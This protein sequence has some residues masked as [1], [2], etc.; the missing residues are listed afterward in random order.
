DFTATRGFL[1]RVSAGIDLYQ[2]VP[3]ATWLIQ[4]IDPL[5]GEVLQ[6]TT[7]GLLKPNDAL[8]SGAGFVSYSIE[9]SADAVTGAEV[10]A[11]ARVLF[12]TQAPEDTLVLAQPVDAAAPTTTL[13]VTRI[14]TGQSFNVA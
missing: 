1:L 14:G 5:T 2:E 10:E 3:A 12:D 9:A 8:G 11:S 7:R 4:A 13:A 6:D